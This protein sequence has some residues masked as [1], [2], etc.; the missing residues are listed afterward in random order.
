M[1]KVLSR[2]ESGRIPS[3]LALFLSGSCR[4]A[5][6]FAAIILLEPLFTIAPKCY[7]LM[8]AHHFFNLYP[9]R[10]RLLVDR[11]CVSARPM[12]GT[13]QVFTSERIYPHDRVKVQLAKLY[14][15]VSLCA[16]VEPSSTTTSHRPYLAVPDFVVPWLDPSA[17]SY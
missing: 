11:N 13:H 5:F 14:S 6:M 15:A 16:T 2:F 1:K 8:I 12:L 9:N 4:E 17:G 10:H 3:Q 7:E